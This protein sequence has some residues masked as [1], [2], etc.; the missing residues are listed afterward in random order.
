MTEFTVGTKD[1]RDA[2]RAVRVH[3]DKTKTGGEGDGACHRVRL[4]FG[5]SELAV[6]A[7][8]IVTT[9]VA[10]VPLLNDEGQPVRDAL[11]L[12]DGDGKLPPQSTI[13][14]VL[15]AKAALM[16]QAFKAA[17]HDPDGVAQLLRFTILED[18][19]EVTDVSG[20]FAGDA[21][22]MQGAGKGSAFPDVWGI[23]QAAMHATGTEPSS[24]PLTAPGVHVSRFQIASKVYEPPLTISPTGTPESRGFLVECGPNFLGVISS[25]H[26]DDD[27]L[28]KRN[29]AR[30]R[31][32]Q[33]FGR[34]PLAA[35]K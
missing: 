25:S 13:V 14:D 21:Y 16:L 20:L 27:S 12:A 23:V 6:M 8:C 34:A 2:L 7:T 1:L 32:L 18:G 5:Q 9:A 3:A 31:W 17:R 26:N 15:P 10:T 30:T 22:V 19:V 24:K 4:S 35:V 28:G 29:A 33:R 11:D